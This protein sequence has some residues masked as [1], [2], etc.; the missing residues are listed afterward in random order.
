METVTI[1][2]SRASVAPDVE[3]LAWGAVLVGAVVVMLIHRA[4]TLRNR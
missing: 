1:A 2:A 4:R 3:M